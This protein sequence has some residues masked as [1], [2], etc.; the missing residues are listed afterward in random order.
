MKVYRAEYPDGGGPFYYRNGIPRY[1]S[2]PYFENN[3]YLS[4]ADSLEHLTELITGYG[5]NIKDF[6]V[7]IYYSNQIISYNRKSGHVTFLEVGE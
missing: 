7:K 4:G 5:F 1:S 3:R 6:I 2:L